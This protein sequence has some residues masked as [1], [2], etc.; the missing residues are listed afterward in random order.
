MPM[1]DYQCPNGHTFES[2]E[3]V[4]VDSVD[5]PSC[6]SWARKVWISSPP[7]V[8]GDSC[9]ITQE[10]GFK[11]VQHFTSKAERRRALREQH[12]EEAV[13]HIGVPGTDKSPHTQSWA[14]IGPNTLADAKAM[15]ERVGGITRSDEAIEADLQRGVDV[16]D[17]QV[18]VVTTPDGR[19]ISVSIGKVYRGT[20]D[21][22]I[23]KR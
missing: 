17:I 4:G 9:N 21:S 20:L 22:S 10:N 11:E 6:C 23:L 7:S 3:K 1:Y 5:C 14:A 19:S 12:V 16:G 13:R 18:P 2:L 8:I 15:L